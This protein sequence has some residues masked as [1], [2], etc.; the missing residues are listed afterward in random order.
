MDGWWVDE[1]DE[2]MDDDDDD[3]GME[4]WMNEWIVCLPRLWFLPLVSFSLP[5]LGAF[6]L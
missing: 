1:M 4:G 2:Y 3:G 6:F 5:F